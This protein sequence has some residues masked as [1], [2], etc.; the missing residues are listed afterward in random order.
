MNSQC[1]IDKCEKK[2]CMP[3][4]YTQMCVKHYLAKLD[5]DQRERDASFKARMEALLREKENQ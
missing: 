3:E 5:K 1:T 4:P 2:S